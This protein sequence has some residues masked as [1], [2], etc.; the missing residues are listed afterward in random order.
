MIPECSK[1]I[2]LVGC[3]FIFYSHSIHV[4][5]KFPN[6]H[7]PHLQE[8]IDLCLSLGLQMYIDVKA[9]TQ[10]GKVSVSYLWSG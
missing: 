3:L 1:L 5:D 10:A 6:E 4:R 9:A 8:V 7:I 2:E